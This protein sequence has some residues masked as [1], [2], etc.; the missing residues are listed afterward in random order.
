MR[1]NCTYLILTFFVITASSTMSMAQSIEKLEKLK[2]LASIQANEGHSNEKN[3]Q[4]VK[5]LTK[6]QVNKNNILLGNNHG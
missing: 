4:F 3:N 2:T 1:N 6:A 5:K